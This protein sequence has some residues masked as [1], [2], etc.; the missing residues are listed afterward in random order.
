MCKLFISA[1]DILKFQQPCLQCHPVQCGL[2][3]DFPS[4]LYV[5]V[6]V[7]IHVLSNSQYDHVNWNKTPNEVNIKRSNGQ[8]S[9]SLLPPELIYSTADEPINT[10]GTNEEVTEEGCA[11]CHTGFANTNIM[12]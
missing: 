3:Y 12:L 10:Q 5:M 7:Y 6:H 9:E 1:E 2:Q 4:L 8:E 11:N